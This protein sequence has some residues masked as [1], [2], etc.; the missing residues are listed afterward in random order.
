MIIV[1]SSF[2]VLGVNES[3]NNIHIYDYNVHRNDKYEIRLKPNKYYET[4][5]LPRD[6]CYAS[7]SID[8]IKINFN[9][10]FNANHKAEINYKYNVTGELIGKVDNEKEVWNRKYKLSDDCCDSKNCTD[11]VCANKEVNI[12]YKQYNNLARDYEKEYGI[13][14][15]TILKVK[16]NIYFEINSFEC[17]L[18]NE[19][20]EDC[21]ELEIPI[22]NTVTEIR[23]NYEDTNYNTINNSNI[24]A[25]EVIYYVVGGATFLGVVILVIKIIVKNNNCKTEKEKHEKKIRKILKYYKTLVVTV[26]EKPDLKDLKIMNIEKLEDLIDLAEQSEKNIIHYECEKENKSKL[27]V[28]VDEYVYVYDVMY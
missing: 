21:I 13:K 17:N 6:Y 4:E 7:Q 22:T 8:N 16:L 9:Y 19:K 5:T 11:K 14:I 23:K 26:K 18:K 3:K 12:D 2:I 27:Y 10:E 25:K 24:E 15:N 1:G 28:I 20:I